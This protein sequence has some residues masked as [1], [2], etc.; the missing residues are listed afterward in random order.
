MSCNQK[1]AWFNLA[2]IGLTLVVVFS[3]VPFLGWQ[4]AQGG[5]GLSGLLGFGAFFFRKQPGRVAMDERDQQIQFRSLTF[6]Y[7]AVF[8]ITYV[9]V[10]VFLVPAIYGQ[11]GAVPV[12]VVQ[13]SVFWAMIL[14][15][16]AMSI[17]ILIQY[18]GV[19]ANVE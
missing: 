7:G 5:F 14:T 10:A 18:G 15:Q 12:S 2:V 19:S 13:F 4:R 3:L 16:A 11:S 8:W 1:F 9:F 17:G 6:A